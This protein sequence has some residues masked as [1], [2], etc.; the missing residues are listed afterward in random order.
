MSSI[1]C[2]RGWARGNARR[3][4]DPDDSNLLNQT[5]SNCRRTSLDVM[6]WGEGG[7]RNSGEFDEDASLNRHPLALFD[8]NVAIWSD[9]RVV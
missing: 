8:S 9:S 4:L 5:I 1:T 6:P 3:L 2:E 7:E